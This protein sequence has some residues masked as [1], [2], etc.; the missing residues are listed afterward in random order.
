M[1]APRQHKQAFRTLAEA[2]EAQGKRRQ[3]GEKQPPTRQTFEEY[4][5]AWLGNY[6]GRTRR[7]RPGDLTEKHCCR[8]VERAVKF[9]GSRQRLGDVEPPHVRAYVREL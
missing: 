8:S 9:F 4:A 1:G 3:H 5:R 6:A 2:R 7:G